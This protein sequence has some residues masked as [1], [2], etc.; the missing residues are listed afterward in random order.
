MD[1][2]APMDHGWISD[3]EI[4]FLREKNQGDFM[5]LKADIH[6]GMKTELEALTPYL[7][8]KEDR[9]VDFEMQASP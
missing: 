7:R 9:S 4:F 3:H 8:D 6:D 2:L 1:L 5:Y